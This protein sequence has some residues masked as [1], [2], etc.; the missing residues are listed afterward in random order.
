MDRLTKRIKFPDGGGTVD[1][2][3]GKTEFL[4]DHAAGVRALFEK[5]A[6][7]EDLQE[8]GRLVELPCEL[9]DCIY[10]ISE[11]ANG[12]EY[13]EVYVIKA[14]YIEL[15]LDERGEINF[16]IGGY[17][18]K[19]EDFGKTVFLTREEAETALKQHE[20]GI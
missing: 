17:D 3:N 16:C 15:S 4:R 6:H 20:E 7:Y 12:C 19:K 2:A 14:Y 13:P 1:F 5:L 18:Y 9:G 10:D 11:F 8:A